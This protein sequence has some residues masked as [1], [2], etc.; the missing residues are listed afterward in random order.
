MENRGYR[1]QTNQHEEMEMCAEM[2]ELISPTLNILRTVLFL[3]R[4]SE[5]YVTSGATRGTA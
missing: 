3:C 1:A 5:C 4:E 2:S